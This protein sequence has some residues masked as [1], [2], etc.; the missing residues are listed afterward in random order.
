MF[1]FSFPP[2]T[3]FNI[4]TEQSVVLYMPQA[5]DHDQAWVDVTSFSSFKY[6]VAAC[7]D[8][9]LEL[10]A[11]HQDDASAILYRIRMGFQSNRKTRIENMQDGHSLDVDTPQILNCDVARYFWLHW[12]AEGIQLGRGERLMEDIIFDYRPTEGVH[13][14]Y[15]VGLENRQ[16]SVNGTQW[17][18][19]IIA[20]TYSI[21]SCRLVSLF[22]TFSL[23]SS[24]IKLQTK[25]VDLLPLQDI[26]ASYTPTLRKVLPR[27]GGT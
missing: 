4:L 25:N 12:D 26:P 17:N 3:S 23:P 20:G 9:R 15:A 2:W 14:I 19:D 21:M 11:K 6:R 18:Y 1:F 8:A 7:A 5:Q 24:L 22:L 27:H 10:S 13:I 16:E